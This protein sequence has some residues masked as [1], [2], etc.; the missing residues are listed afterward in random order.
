[1]KTLGMAITP[2]SHVFLKMR[3]ESK[4][5]IKE[6]GILAGIRVAREI[7]SITD[8]DLKHEILLEDGTKLYP[9]DIA[10]YHLRTAAINT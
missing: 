8:R 10:F 9:G 1:M 4:T 7:F 3:Q 2:R 5:L 6:K